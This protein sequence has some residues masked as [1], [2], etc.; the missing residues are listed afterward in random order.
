MHGPELGAFCTMDW[1]SNK[2]P[3]KFIVGDLDL[4]YNNPGV[5]DYIHKG[6]FKASVPNLEDVCCYGGSESLHQPGEA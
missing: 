3:R 2:S 6:G 5:Q 4:T 1:C